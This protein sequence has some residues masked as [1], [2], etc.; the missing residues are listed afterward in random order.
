M[1][2]ALLKAMRYYNGVS[3]RIIV[4]INVIN[5]RIVNRE[6]E[7]DRL[8]DEELQKKLLIH[9][10]CIDKSRKFSR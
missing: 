9:Y 10:S 4:V 3:G 7:A 1:I 8:T 5:K 2:A 6:I